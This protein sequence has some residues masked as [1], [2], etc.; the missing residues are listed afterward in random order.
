MTQGADRRS[1]VALAGAGLA[2]ALSVTGCSFDFS[3][4]DPEPL[5]A[6]TEEAGS[7][8]AGDETPPPAPGGEEGGGALG[9]CEP[10]QLLAE[11]HEQPSGSAAEV[12]AILTLSNA[13]T[14]D[15][16]LP[17]GWAPLG[18][19]GGGGPYFAAVE[20]AREPH[21]NAGT[22]ITL[23]PGATAYAGLKWGTSPQ[24]PSAGGWAVAWRDGWLPAKVTWQDGPRDICP[25][26]F[27]QGTLQPT[28][29]DVNYG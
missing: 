10:G 1:L 16:V 17:K 5:A 12:R 8:T 19:G 6:E 18:Q 28:P 21:P 24:C 15:C 23:R 9:V 26:T 29:N 25:G 22:N 11:L 7:V 27:A 4:G 20:G 3:V 2:L 14:R 13:S